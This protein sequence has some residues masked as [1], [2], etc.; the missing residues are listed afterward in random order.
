MLSQN[1]SSVR[2]VFL[3][4]WLRTYNTYNNS[5]LNVNIAHIFLTITQLESERRISSL[6]LQIKLHF[7]NF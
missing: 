3:L 4:V 1:S 6:N 2:R 7:Y 5:G